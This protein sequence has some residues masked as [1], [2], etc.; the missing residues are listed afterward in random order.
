MG[1]DWEEIKIIQSLPQMSTRWT[2]LGAQR[3]ITCLTSSGI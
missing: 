2:G 3:S 1:K